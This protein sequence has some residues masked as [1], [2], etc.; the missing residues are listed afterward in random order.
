MDSAFTTIQFEWCPN[1]GYS[2]M[3][4][5]NLSTWIIE[6]IVI[7]F[8]FKSGSLNLWNLEYKS[9]Y[10]LTV[11]HTIMYLLHL[12]HLFKAPQYTH[13]LLEEFTKDQQE[14]FFPNHL[15]CC[16]FLASDI[17][18]NNHQLSKLWVLF[19]QVNRVEPNMRWQSSSLGLGSLHQTHTL[20]CS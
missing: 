4:C 20:S 18:N 12:Y 3:C 10:Y 15:Q 19:L 16:A 17:F 5:N 13:H 9:D 8:F 7:K 11:L 6:N 14:I 1:W 2:I